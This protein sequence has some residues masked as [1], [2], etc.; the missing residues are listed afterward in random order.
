MP[1]PTRRVIPTGYHICKLS[2]NGETH[3]RRWSTGV[4]H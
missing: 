1:G 3:S 4:V 2:L